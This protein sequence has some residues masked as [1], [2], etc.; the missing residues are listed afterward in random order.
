[1][2]N[3]SSSDFC[4]VHSGMF[5]LSLQ[6]KIYLSQICISRLLFFTATYMYSI[7]LHPFVTE[8]D[9]KIFLSVQT[10]GLFDGAVH[11]YTCNIMQEYNSPIL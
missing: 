1:M 4:E 3:G 9:S 8:L 2:R 7:L 6:V 11:S 5:T 10:N